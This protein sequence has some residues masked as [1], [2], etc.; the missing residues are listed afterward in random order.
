MSHD[1]RRERMVER[2]AGVAG[3]E[4]VGRRAAA[5]W[6]IPRDVSPGADYP[7]R[8][9]TPIYP[10][11]PRALRT[12]RPPLL[13]RRKGRPLVRSPVS[14]FTYPRRWHKINF[15]LQVRALF[16]HGLGL[17]WIFSENTESLTNY[18]FTRAG[19]SYK[20][21]GK[22]DVV[23]RF[24][25]VLR[26]KSYMRHLQTKIKPDGVRFLFYFNGLQIIWR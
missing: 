8:M 6:R 5:A 4:Q 10:W 3:V 7:P 18:F 20:S 11:N 13:G 24:R 12:P 1:R 22:F 17:R 26:S 19:K 15:T 14:T 23:G 9:R 25:I 21:S 2:Q 16:F